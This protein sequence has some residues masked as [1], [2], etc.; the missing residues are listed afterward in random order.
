MSTSDTLLLGAAGIEIFLFVTVCAVP[1][2]SFLA[3][4]IRIIPVRF[5]QKEEE[6]F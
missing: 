1:L 6:L 2:A 4:A 5:Q 3:E